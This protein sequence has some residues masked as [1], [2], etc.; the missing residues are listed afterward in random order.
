[1]EDV[2]SFFADIRL[3]MDNSTTRKIGDL[4]YGYNYNKIGKIGDIIDKYEYDKQYDIMNRLNDLFNYLQKDYK[5]IKNKNTLE[6][7]IILAR[8]INECG[9]CRSYFF[10]VDELVHRCV[11]NIIDDPVAIN[12]ITQEYTK[13]LDEHGVVLA[14]CDELHDLDMAFYHA[15][16]GD[17][18]FAVFY[19]INPDNNGN[20]RNGDYE[21]Y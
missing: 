17:E 3:A 1:M 12:L 2:S 7:M 6:I 9:D 14:N 18:N 10:T 16:V 20:H 8:I 4:I 15:F 21:D 5:K 19:K 13:L 11:S